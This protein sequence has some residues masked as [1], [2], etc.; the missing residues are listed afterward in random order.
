MVHTD[1]DQSGAVLAN[2]WTEEDMLDVDIERQLKIHIDR[3]TL[4]RINDKAIA[5]KKE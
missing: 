1:L 4:Q 2:R 3:W 5:N